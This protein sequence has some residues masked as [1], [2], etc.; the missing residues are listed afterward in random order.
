VQVRTICSPQT[1]GSRAGYQNSYGLGPDLSDDQ[2]ID[3]AFSLCFDT[4]PLT[5]RLELLGAAELELDICCDQPQ[6]LLAVRL[7]DVAPDG[8]SLRL[9]YGL[10]NL[11][12]RDSHATPEAL[13]PGH[14]YHVRI[15]FGGLA[16]AL[17]PGHCL[18]LALST[19]Y[20]PIAWP[21]PASA[22]VS[23]RCGSSLL[24]LPRRA[25]NVAM[26]LALAP[27]DE[28]EGAG[29][30][31]LQ[32]TRARV[33]GHSLDRLEEHLGEGRVDL[34][35]TRDRGAWRT[36]D[37]DVDYDTHG[38]LRFSIQ[39]DDP[40]S[41]EQSIDLH[42]SMGREGWRIRTRAQ[43]VIRCTADAFLIEAR[44]EAWEGEQQVF[45]RRWDHR[46]GRDQV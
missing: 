37:T 36:L 18:R 17:A 35:R 46:I 16:Y 26:D 11:S 45:E 34:H 25:G 24:R 4:E 22:K 44:L 21:S 10:L 9:D 6:A 27:F 7:C 1:T 38:D 19:A 29:P 33:L 30:P 42:T 20:W 32:E 15:P 12:H 31:T 43:T 28:P 3:D 40:L 8:S 41:A 14:W 39:A 2:R 13:V 5:E 23:V